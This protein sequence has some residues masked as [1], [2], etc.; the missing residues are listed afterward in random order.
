VVTKVD[1]EP[2]VHLEDYVVEGRLELSLKSYLEPVMAN[3][4]N[5]SLRRLERG[6]VVP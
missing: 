2:P 4:A 1:L 6:I 3:N 5:I